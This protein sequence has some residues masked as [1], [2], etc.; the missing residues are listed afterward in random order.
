MGQGRVLVQERKG[1][2]AEVEVEVVAEGVQGLA[3][4]LQE[5]GQRKEKHPEVW[6]RKSSM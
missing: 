5:E 3:I 6:K 1:V 4:R 2:G